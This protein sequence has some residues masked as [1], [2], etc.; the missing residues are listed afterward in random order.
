MV[1]GL[2]PACHFA[3]LH[4][5]D[6]PLLWYLGNL[7]GMFTCFFIGFYIRKIEI[8][9]RYAPGSWDVLN[10]HAIW[11]IL[12]ALGTFIWYIGLMAFL[13]DRLEGTCL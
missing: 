8:P 9:E 10:S 6:S 3:W 11:H 13:E 1:F 7:L 12:V 4:G 5:L 2:V